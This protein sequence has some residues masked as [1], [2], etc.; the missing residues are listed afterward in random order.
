MNRATAAKH[1]A[2][3]KTAIALD[4]ACTA[5]RDYMRKCV[6]DAEPLKGADDS[7]QILVENMSEYASFL[8]GRHDDAKGV[9][10]K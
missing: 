3:A 8:H 1:K 7:R 10:A 9:H 4:K 5:L 2:G 6:A